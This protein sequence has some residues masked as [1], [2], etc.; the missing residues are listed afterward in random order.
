M[1]EKNPAFTMMSPSG[2]KKLTA[3]ESRLLK[4]YKNRHLAKLE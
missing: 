2:N 1:L 4:K 3:S